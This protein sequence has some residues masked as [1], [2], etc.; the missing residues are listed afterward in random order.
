MM[1]A[2]SFGLAATAM[3]GNYMELRIGVN[4]HSTMPAPLPPYC[5]PLSLP[6]PPCRKLASQAEV[7]L[8][9][10]L[11]SAEGCEGQHFWYIFSPESVSSGL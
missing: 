2:A 8:G 6:F 11:R 10:A 9:S 7:G 5:L 1:Q 3:V 4:P